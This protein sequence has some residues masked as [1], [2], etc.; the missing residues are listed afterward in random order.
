MYPHVGPYTP[1]F[2]FGYEG[3]WN[4]LTMWPPMSNPLTNPTTSPKL[5]SGIAQIDIV[6]NHG[7]PLDEDE[8]YLKRKHN[9]K[10]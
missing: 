2:G 7:E 4:V 9:P 6:T 5:V 10:M 3:I 8:N 1:Y